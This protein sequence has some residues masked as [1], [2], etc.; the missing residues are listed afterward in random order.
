M[1]AQEMGAQEA[2]LLLLYLDDPWAD[3]EAIRHEMAEKENGR[4]R[5]PWGSRLLG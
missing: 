5:R 1:G 2:P 4:G 3:C